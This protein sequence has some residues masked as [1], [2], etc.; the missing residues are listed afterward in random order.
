MALLPPPPPN[1]PPNSRNPQSHHPLPAL[2]DRSVVA[3]HVRDGT[4]AEGGADG[5]ED[6]GGV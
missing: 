1:I 5:G 6:G 3:A 4:A 2:R